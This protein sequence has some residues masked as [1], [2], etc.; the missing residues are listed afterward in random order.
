VPHRRRVT[1]SVKNSNQSIRIKNS[2]FC[3]LSYYHKMHLVTRLRKHF[4]S[5]FKIFPETAEAT[6]RILLKIYKPAFWF[7]VSSIL[8]LLNDFAY[9]SSSSFG[10]VPIFRINSR[11][12]PWATSSSTSPKHDFWSWMLTTQ[13]TSVQCFLT[14]SPRW[15]IWGSSE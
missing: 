6:E 7:Q 2:N 10:C 4:I 11:Q 14:G 12:S 3:N 1:I 15:K 9:I 13:Y 8:Y 5:N